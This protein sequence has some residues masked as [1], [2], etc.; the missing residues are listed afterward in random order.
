MVFFRFF[1][2]VANSF[3]ENSTNVIRLQIYNYSGISQQNF[4][5]EIKNQV[6]LPA[7]LFT[8]RLDYSVRRITLLRIIETIK[9]V[10]FGYQK[11]ESLLQKRNRDS[12]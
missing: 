2:Y 4:L 9:Y 1:W 7:A 11:K 6:F 12:R 3:K 5:G 10:S 8:R